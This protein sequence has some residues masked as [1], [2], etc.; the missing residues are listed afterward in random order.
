M[1]M[2]CK[3]ILDSEIS[4]KDE[5]E[6]Q[7]IIQ[8]SC[9]GLGDHLIYSSLPELLLEQKCIKTFISNKSVFRSVAIRDFVWGLNP[10][11]EFTD[12]KGWFK[13]KTQDNKFPTVDGYFQDLFNLRGDGLPRVYYMPNVVEQLRGKTII[14]PSCGAAGKANGYFEQDFYKRFIE[15]IKNNVGEF[16]LI[17][18][19]HSGTK[20]ALQELIR[21][22]F[23]PKCY[24]V[25]TIEEL[26][27]TL[28]SAN[29]RYLLHSGSASLAAALKLES[30][31]LNYIKPSTYDCFKYPTNRHIHL[32]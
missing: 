10:Y 20:N 7:L 14:D 21:K 18:H 6:K 30:N 8:V 29:E 32:L 2:P 4:A 26:S 28:Y 16:V 25:S 24:S 5:K 11:V 15:Y 9:G 22:E 17:I 19:N 31:I 23:E 13:Y 27:D 12:E 1:I 3:P